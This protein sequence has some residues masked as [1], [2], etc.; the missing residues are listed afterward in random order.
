M[1]L[2]CFSQTRD[3]IDSL[4]NLGSSSARYLSKHQAHLLGEAYIRQAR[5]AMKFV[6]DPILEEYINTLGN[7]LKQYSDASF[8]TPD[9]FNFYFIENPAINAFAVPG[10]HIAINT[11]LINSTDTEAELA[12]VLT[13]EIAHVTQNHSARGMEGS[14]Y[15]SLIS[16]ATILVAAASGSAD[17]AQAGIIAGQ[18]SIR[19][20][21]LAYSRRFE[22]EADATG[23]RTL[24]KAGYPPAATSTFLQKLL[25]AN[26]FNGAAVPEFLLSHPVTVSRI[27]EAE[28]RIKSYPPLE[29]P[30]KSNTDFI[31]IKARISALYS[32]NPERLSKKLAKEITK[33]KKLGVEISDSLHYEYGLSLGEANDTEQAL[34][35]LRKAAKKSPQKVAY[36]IAIAETELEND[37]KAVGLDLFKKIYQEHEASMPSIALYY[38]NALILANQSKLAIPVLIKIQKRSP[39]EPYTHIMLA[40]AYGENDRLFDS[41]VSR[42]EYHY[43]RGNFAFAVKQLENAIAT[44]PNDIEKSI[45][46]NKKAKIQLELDETKKALS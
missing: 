9:K 14:R 8:N 17:A 33:Q 32:S 37:N 45:L 24:Y 22:R 21:Q 2:N 13:H 10:G 35:Q 34:I 18:G 1:S 46:Q 31:D 11:G 39:K 4:P 7:K 26:Q 38:A 30:K 15:D 29:Q 25:S 44:A 20:K 28:Q 23:I 36:Q 6:N 40:R 12:S 16:I 42:A 19:Q 43:L 27:S 5:G 41:Y 3:V